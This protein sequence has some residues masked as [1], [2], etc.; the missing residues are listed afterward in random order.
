MDCAGR[1]VGTRTAGA[2]TPAPR[3]LPHSGALDGLRGV[4]VL[5]VI[6]LHVGVLETGYIGVDIFFAL[7][8]FLITT[9]LYDEWE[10]T[11]QISLRRFYERRARRLLPALWLVVAMFATVVA[12]AHPFAGMWP[13]GRLT[14]TTLLFANNWVSAL[15]PAHG[16][17]LGALVPT[18]TLAQEAQFYILWPAA[19]CIL[20]RRGARPHALLALLAFGIIVL[21]ATLPLVRH[22]YPSYNTYVNPFDRGAEL[23][24]GCAV[25]TAWHAQLIPAALRSRVTGWVLAGGLAGVLALTAANP[26]RGVRLSAAILAALLIPTLLRPQSLSPVAAEDPSRRGVLAAILRSRPVRSTGRISYGLYLYHLPVYYLMWHY[27]PGRSRYFY[28]PLVLLLSY[29]AADLSWRF[30]ERPVITG[31]RP[32]MTASGI[33]S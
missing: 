6:C 24:L 12:I 8:G 29:A 18:W 25:A 5:L 23:L 10:G 11:G 21:F 26:E 2:E 19:L 7:S 4:A 9:L 33:V 14:A 13:V 1:S 20:L 17:V 30:I 16:Q 15:A 3:R 27:L 22:A 28:A 31:R 32:S